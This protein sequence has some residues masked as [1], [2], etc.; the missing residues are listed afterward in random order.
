[1]PIE[2]FDDEHADARPNQV[3]AYAEIGSQDGRARALV[4]AYARRDEVHPGKVL[5]GL[6]LVA[7]RLEAGRT[8][9]GTNWS[10]RLDAGSTVARHAGAEHSHYIGKQAP[11]EGRR[12]AF[13]A[14]GAGVLAWRECP[15]PG[16]G[17]GRYPCNW[18]PKMD[19]SADSLGLTEAD[20]E[21]SL[22]LVLTEAGSSSVVR[23]SGVTMRIPDRIWY[24]CP[25]RSTSMRWVAKLGEFGVWRALVRSARYRAYVAERRRAIREFAANQRRASPA[26]EAVAPDG[27]SGIR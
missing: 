22:A 5:V 17:R 12:R 9:A 4:V 25:P 23:L 13:R 21:V 19:T 10:M 2:R 6:Q 20:R 14:D 11:D 1:M 16:S 27:T 24:Q 15:E 26:G 7:L 3:Q 18:S 8:S